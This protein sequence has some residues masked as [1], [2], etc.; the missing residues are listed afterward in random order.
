MIAHTK[1]YV[2]SQEDQKVMLGAHNPF[3]PPSMS[4]WWRVA[5]PVKNCSGTNTARPLNIIPSVK[6]ALMAI[7]KQYGRP[8]GYIWILK[9][10][11][12]ITNPLMQSQNPRTVR[13]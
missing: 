3:P 5:G 7:S 11:I 8:Y 9:L 1:N 10:R 6:P 13:I 12:S 4:W 2:C